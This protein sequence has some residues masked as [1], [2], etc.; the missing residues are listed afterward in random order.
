MS[1]FA[2]GLGSTLVAMAALVPLAGF[3][4]VRTFANPEREGLAVSYCGADSS[5][6][7]EFMA[8]AWCVSAGYEYATDWAARAALGSS[9]RTIRLDDGAICEGPACESFARITCGPEAQTF[10]TPVL[11]PSGKLA[12]LSSDR[13]VV[14]HSVDASEYRVLLPGC[15]QHE[16]G[17]F[18]CGSID[19]Y[20]HCR[21]LMI[22]RMVHSC[23]ADLAFDEGL[24]E[25]R[26]VSQD[27]MHLR[28]VSDALVRT[29]PIGRGRGQ[30]KGAAEISLVFDL[31]A[32]ANASECL[33]RRSYV[34]FPT[35]PDGGHASIGKADDCDEP[36]EFSIAAHADDL[37]RAY[38]LCETFATWGLEIEDSIEVLVASLFTLRSAS[39]PT[40]ET[41]I[42][43]YAMVEA[44]LTIGCGI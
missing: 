24:A 18:V 28:V 7:G 36:I 27:E 9:A 5:S 31:P 12:L 25:P 42:A 13:R 35:G 17:V 29:D 8:T 37:L 6:C 30:I 34:Y 4:Q 22:P 14:E 32:E 2:S 10:T 38:D 20:Q 41:V 26:A 43:P 23:R 3:T 19:A 40:T 33:E 39:Q 21:T 1:S 16:P 44:P 11:G 15:S